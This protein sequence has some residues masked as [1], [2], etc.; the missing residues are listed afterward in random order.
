MTRRFAKLNPAWVLIGFLWFAYLL[1]HADRQ[2]VYTLF[3]ALQKEFGFGDAVVG[4][5][6]ALFLW[7]YGLCSP[8]AGVFGDRYSKRVLVTASL[9][10]WSTFTVLSGL[11]PNGASLL[12]CRALLGVSESVFMPAGYGLM[13]AAHGPRTRSRAIAIFATSQLA[14]VAVG[15]SLS[16]FVAEQLNWRVSFWILG[17]AG[18]L[19]V[20]PL[21][22]FFRSMPRAFYEIPPRS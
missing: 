22:R 16:A 17:A 21:N 1:N 2:V 20:M 8:L 9:A 10:I 15:G 7:V 3:P 19:F 6:G 5:T 14:G 12:A 13:A 4:L 11:S 18:I